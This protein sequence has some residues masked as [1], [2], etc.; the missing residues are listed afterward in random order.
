M[1]V[2]FKGWIWWHCLHALQTYWAPPWPQ[3]ELAL[4]CQLPG[5]YFIRVAFTPISSPWTFSRWSTPRGGL[6]GPS[7]SWVPRTA[8]ASYPQGTL[9]RVL[10]LPVSGLL[11]SHP[12]PWI[13][14]P[15]ESNLASSEPGKAPVLD[16]FN[17]WYQDALRWFEENLPK[18]SEASCAPE[19]GHPQG[20]L[21]FIYAA[22]VCHQK[23]TVKR[24]PARNKYLA[25]EG[26]TQA[27]WRQV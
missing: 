7:P 12:W 11:Q 8:S 26:S 18:F 9:D 15:G 20:Q 3:L 1:G 23:N 10:S 22:G 19:A 25:G 21:L 13:L 24:F 6:Q 27:P 5:E 16:M 2:G 4:S 14:F 17:R